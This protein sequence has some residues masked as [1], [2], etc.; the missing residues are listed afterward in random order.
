MTALG[1]AL[2]IVEACTTFGAEGGN[3]PDAANGPDGSNGT[4]GLDGASGAEASA[5]PDAETQDAGAC[6]VPEGT[7]SP[8]TLCEVSKVTDVTIGQWAFSLV[9]DP[10]HL[11]WIENADR[12][13]NALGGAIR[14]IS[15]RGGAD[16]G[17]PTP[18]LVW[19]T[20]S[21]IP[22]KLALT[23]DDVLVAFSPNQAVEAVRL[24]KGCNGICTPTAIPSSQRVRA[25]TNQRKDP[26]TVESTGVRVGGSFFALS[27][28]NRAGADVFGGEVAVVREGSA[29]L[30]VSSGTLLPSG[31]TFP[32]ADPGDGGTSRGAFAASSDCDRIWAL[33]PF[34]G[35]GH[36]LVAT[37]PDASAPSV[38]WYFT[39]ETFGMAADRTHVYLAHS[40]GPGLYRASATEAPRQLVSGD[41]WS[42]AVTNK[43]VYFDHHH[44][45]NQGTR[46]IERLSKS[47]P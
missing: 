10:S 6:R 12:D 3:P 9:A 45:L 21:A 38:A 43:Y 34:G 11:Y 20:S 17:E 27:S 31:R 33:Q 47:A 37:K 25:I 39:R 29:D 22:T 26:V 46:R 32:L 42:V 35:G 5:G 8:C 16:G 18:E 28:P 23:D 19:F 13:G 44:R 7:A 41:V 14:R 40:D 36:A 24:P 2:G 1:L 15:V 4:T 30:T